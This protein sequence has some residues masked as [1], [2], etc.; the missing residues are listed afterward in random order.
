MEAGSGNGCDVE[1]ISDAITS[2]CLLNWL[3]LELACF[4]SC[5]FLKK[6]ISKWVLIH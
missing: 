3:L 4:H 5:L 2:S 6:K 1:P